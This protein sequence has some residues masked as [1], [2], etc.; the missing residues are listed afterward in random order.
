[1]TTAAHRLKPVSDTAEVRYKRT[2]L[3]WQHWLLVLLILLAFARLTWRLEAKNLWWDESLSLQR[4]E[5]SWGDLL[6][7]RLMLDDGEERLASTDQHPFTYFALL[8]VFVR[9]AGSG[10]FSLRFPSALAATLLVP[11]AWAFARR[12]VRR[13]ILPPA[14]P[15]WAA[16]LTSLNPFYLWYGQEARMYT[17]TPLLALVSV[18]ALL[19]WGD[20]GTRLAQRRWLIGYAAAAASLLSTHYL[21]AMILPVHAGL[22]YQRLAVGNRRRAL[23]LAGSLL[24]GGLLLASAIAWRLLRQPGAGSN[25]QPVPLTVLAPDLLN[26][27]SLGLSVDIGRVWPLDLVFGA[28]A[29]AGAAWSLRARPALRAAGWLLPAFIAIPTFLM[30]AL[31]TVQ[32]AYMNARHLALISPAFLLLVAGGLGWLW[33]RQRLLAGIVGGLLLAGMAYS[34]RNYFALPQYGKD[35]FAGAGAY[36]RQQMQPGDLLIVNPPQMTRLFRYYLPIAA[37]EEAA[38]TGLGA[39]WRALPLLSGDWAAVEARLAA[40]TGRYRRIWLVTSGMFPFADPEK[41]VEGWLGGQ[42]LR[43]RERSF[44]SP[45][46]ILELDLFIP[47]PPAVAQ[48]P[49]PPQYPVNATFGGQIRLAGYDLGPRLTP[50]GALPV[51]LYWQA[52][53]PI[54]R[55]YK[56]LLRLQAS[57]ADGLS[58]TL[59]TTE[60]EPYDGAAPTTAWQLG[61][62]IIEYS[63]ALAPTDLGQIPGCCQLTLQVYDAETLEKL[64]LTQAADAQLASDG[65][66]LRLP[67]L[68]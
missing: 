2:R 15:L 20:A 29:L 8:A 12:L 11:L 22:F 66:T 19:R 61:S 60:R 59:A 9:L 44:A 5:A 67:Y 64:P 39:A 38:P 13:K 4:A 56:Y 31:N 6:S 49:R 23:L 26:A 21:A 14:A 3:R 41:R 42:A 30:L 37:I 27:F 57:S 48:L 32:P 10:E 43:V 53:Q 35:D 33:G 34:T 58:Q 28:L 52:A 7:G 63:E 65:Q 25:F 46:S 18:Y 51:T 17:L 36:L 50:A 47:Q 45:T 68:P 16:F 40:A 54:G 24:L 62:T 55:R 1:M